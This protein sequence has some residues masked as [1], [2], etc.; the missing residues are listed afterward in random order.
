MAENNHLPGYMVLNPVCSGFSSPPM[1]LGWT[2]YLNVHNEI[3]YAREYQPARLYAVP[4]P[5]KNHPNDYYF[6]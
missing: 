6:A 3:E 4:P 2:F 1:V 5:D